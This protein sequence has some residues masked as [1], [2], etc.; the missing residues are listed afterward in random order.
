MGQLASFGPMQPNTLLAVIQCGGAR[1]GG[2]GRAQGGRGVGPA[3]GRAARRAGSA[4]QTAGGGVAGGGGGASTETSPAAGRNVGG[5]GA[6]QG[7]GRGGVRAAQPPSI[8]PRKAACWRAR[9]ERRWCHWWGGGGGVGGG[10]GGP[11]G[12]EGV[13]GIHGGDGHTSEKGAKLAQKFGQLQPF[14][15]VFPQ[16]WMGQPAYFGPI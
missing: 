10:C 14:T 3:E 12:A 15:A 6:A 2:H 13:R 1:Q 16:E 8:S 5:C 9:G 11:G 4:G 7:G